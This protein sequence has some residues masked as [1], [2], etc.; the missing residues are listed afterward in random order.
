MLLSV[1]CRFDLTGIP[2]SGE[3]FVRG[4]ELLLEFG[5]DRRLAICQAK[6]DG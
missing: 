2:K 3:F 4:A 6:S 5:V 1:C